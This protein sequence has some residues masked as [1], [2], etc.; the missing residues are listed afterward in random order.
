V[1]NK[2]FF[3]ANYEGLRRVEGTTQ[4]VGV[5][6]ALEKE[7]NFSQS[8]TI[9]IDPTTDE[10]FPGDTIPSTRINTVASNL[11]QFYPLPNL[12]T[13]EY[14]SAIPAPE[15]GNQ[16]LA[17]V[18]QNLGTRDRITYDYQY[19]NLSLIDPNPVT[20]YGAIGVPGFGTRDQ[21]TFNRGIISETHTFG[22]NTVNIA[23][24]TYNR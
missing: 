2:W 8:S 15:T 21:G 23:R 5:P 9:P 4:N 18:D 3:F 13:N 10:P 11:L 6:T 20:I 14:V 19:R 7:G 1:K 12:G 22:L 17:K 24:F 16:F